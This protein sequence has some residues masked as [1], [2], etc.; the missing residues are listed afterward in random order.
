MKVVDIQARRLGGF[1][2]CERTPPIFDWSAYFS[3]FIGM[4]AKSNINGRV[5]CY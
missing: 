4:A 2:G 5:S 1:G 3:L